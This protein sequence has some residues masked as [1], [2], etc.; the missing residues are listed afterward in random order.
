MDGWM[1]V[2]MGGQTGAY[3]LVGIEWSFMLRTLLDK[4]IDD[5]LHQGFANPP[6]KPLIAI[7]AQM[8][9]GTRPARIARR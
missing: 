9:C 3:A 2:E 8:R 4:P 6:V 5:T 7:V 1:A